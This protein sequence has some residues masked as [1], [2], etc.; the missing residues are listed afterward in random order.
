M[1]DLEYLV[2]KTDDLE[3]RVSGAHQLATISVICSFIL[4]LVLLLEV[5]K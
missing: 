2:R 1:T 3:Q 4:G 5:I